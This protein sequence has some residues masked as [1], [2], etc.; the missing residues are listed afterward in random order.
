MVV[1][2]RRYLAVVLMAA[3]V[4]H[5]HA[6][7]E[8]LGAIVNASDPTPSQFS[9]FKGFGLPTCKQI[10]DT[11]FGSAT[12]W[13]TDMPPNFGV[14]GSPF[15]LQCCSAGRAFYDEIS[16]HWK[17]QCQTGKWDID[18]PEG[19]APGSALKMKNPVTGEQN[20]VVVPA[21]LAA[22]QSFRVVMGE[23]PPV[24]GKR[25]EFRFPRR[26][27]KGDAAVVTCTLGRT[28]VSAWIAG[29]DLRLGVR[30]RRSGLSTWVGV[31]TCKANALES[32]TAPPFLTESI[33]FFSGAAA[34]IP[35]RAVL[36]AAALVA[37][38]LLVVLNF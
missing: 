25:W 28:N 13:A 9:C 17:L 12:G 1:V 7:M 21:G 30:E 26:A 23:L 32:A 5:V 19:A 31:E 22:G 6:A 36:A 11:G 18:V 20:V 14:S 4:D 34:C 33:T 24:D 38:L 29:Y 27:T 3:L 10:A 2:H 37:N 35:S 15:C 8:L 16:D